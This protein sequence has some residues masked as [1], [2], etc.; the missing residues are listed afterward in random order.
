[1][2]DI[3]ALPVFSREIFAGV[4][5]LGF[6]PP[7]TPKIRTAHYIPPP[8][9]LVVDFT[10]PPNFQNCVWMILPDALFPF[11]KPDCPVMSWTNPVCITI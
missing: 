9:R 11:I 7:N 4:L 6:Q 10:Q 5:D 1:M 8:L 2:K 3:P